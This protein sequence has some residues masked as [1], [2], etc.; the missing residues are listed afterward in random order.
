MTGSAKVLRNSI[1]QGSPI[2]LDANGFAGLATNDFTAF[3]VATDSAPPG[4]IVTYSTDGTV[5]RSDWTLITGKKSLNQGKAYFL[6]GTGKLAAAGNQQI[7]VAK[8][9]T[10]LNILILQ[11][12]EPVTQVHTFRGQPPANLGKIGDLLINEVSLALMKKGPDG[13]QHLAK[14]VQSNV[15]GPITLVQTPT[16]WGAYF[17]AT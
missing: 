17:S 10:V 2:Y 11:S 13:W 5:E 6:S 9:K 3:A 12:S 1:I 8:S 16:G 15:E 7:G 4:G 14:F